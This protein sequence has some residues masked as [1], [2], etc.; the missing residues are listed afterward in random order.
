VP[1]G[2]KLDGAGVELLDGAPVGVK[3]D[4]H[5][6]VDV[7]PGTSCS[8]A[9]ILTLGVP[10]TT[11]TNTMNHEWYSWPITNGTQYHCRITMHS[12]N[13]SNALLQHGPSCSSLTFIANLTS[14]SLCAAF[15]ATSNENMYCDVN[16]DLTGPDSY[17]IVADT[18]PC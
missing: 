10:Y 7:P 1:A 15:T 14:L 9:K 3:L 2:V 5:G 6:I 13:F 11:N 16:P 8:T 12:A 4:G 18:G 17:T